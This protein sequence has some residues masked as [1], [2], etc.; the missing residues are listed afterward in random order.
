MEGPSDGLREEIGERLS[1]IRSEEELD[2]LLGVLATEPALDVELSMSGDPADTALDDD[3][4]QE[5]LAV[6]DAWAGL[7]SA[8]VGRFYAPASP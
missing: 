3:E 5:P 2:G 1:T 4:A 8:V 7:A 6:V